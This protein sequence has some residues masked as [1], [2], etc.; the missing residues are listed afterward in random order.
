MS[1]PRTASGVLALAVGIAAVAAVAAW[2]T[3]TRPAPDDARPGFSFLVPVTTVAVATGDVAESI[4]LVGDVRAPER[5]ALAFERAGRIAEL[6][7]RV[8]DMVEAGEVLARLDD[9]V[10]RE[11]VRSSEASLAQSREMAELAVRDSERLKRIE[12]VGATAAE[13]DR[14]EAAARNEAAKVAQMEADLALQRAR[15]KQGVLTAPF[16]AVVTSRPVALGSYVAAGDACCELLSLER[17]EIELD[18]PPSVAAVVQPGS[19]VT[20]TSDALPGFALEADLHAVLPSPDARARTFTGL[21]RIG[22]AAD[23]RQRLRPG[24]FVRGIVELRAARG[25]L[26]VPV[27]CLLEGGAEVAVAVVVPGETP[28]AAR[29]P[30]EL[31][32]RD[33]RRAAVLPRA[34]ATLA[35]G[36]LVILVGKENAAPGK[37]LLAMPHA[38]PLP[39]DA[40]P[41]PAPGGP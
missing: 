19:R 26:T 8:G 34:G 25:A 12:D 23:P 33:S 24:M 5:A 14:A 21:V 31:L 6:P 16:A 22:A 32:A 38:A 18:L 4:P 13:I 39:E 30:V 29:V 36:D 15:L 3:R 37:P 28:T 9:S 41:E 7:I 27:D 20:L 11:E 10:M 1:T 40:R 17:R 35:A 2:M